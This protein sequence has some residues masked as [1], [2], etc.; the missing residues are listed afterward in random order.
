[1]LI[2]LLAQFAVGQFIMLPLGFGTTMTR[3]ILLGALCG[4]RALLSLPETLEIDNV[5]HDGPET[6][7]ARLSRVRAFKSSSMIQTIT[8]FRPR[9]KTAVP[10]A[11][12]RRVRNMSVAIQFNGAFLSFTR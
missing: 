11:C 6:A 7:S 4:V 8:W 12:R 5:A 9:T 2:Q 3:T 1:M 10:S